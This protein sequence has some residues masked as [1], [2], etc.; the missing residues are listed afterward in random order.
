MPN[1]PTT[2]LRVL[3]PLLALAAAPGL[4]AEPPRTL[5]FDRTFSAAGEPAFL[6]YNVLFASNGAVH[7]MELWRDHDRSI[8]RVTDAA[9][10]TYA[11]RKGKDAGYTLKVLDLKRRI[12]TVIERTNLYRIGSFTDWYDLGHG[13]RHPKSAYRLVAAKAPAGM[14]RIGR[15]CRW[16]DLIEGSR[17]THVCWDEQAKLPL[18]MAPASGPPIWRVTAI[19]QRPIP[20]ATFVADDRGFIRNDANRDIE[21]D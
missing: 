18:L 3:L 21:A 11:T 19:D 1:L 12:S 14:P 8:K 17:T 4:A 9:L 20:A 10:V 7:R 13:L 6:H 16:Y 5:S 2:G 15:P